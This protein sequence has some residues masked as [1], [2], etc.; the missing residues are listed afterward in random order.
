MTITAD[1]DD[2]RRGPEFETV[3]L[4]DGET[5]LKIPSSCF[6]HTL[7]GREREFRQSSFAELAKRLLPIVSSDRVE[8]EDYAV[9]SEAVVALVRF[10]PQILN[11]TRLEEA[12]WQRA[13]GSD[14]V[15]DYSP[16]NA[17]E[18][19]TKN[20]ILYCLDCLKL[21]ENQ[22]LSTEQIERWREAILVAAGYSLRSLEVSHRVGETK[23]ND[24]LGALR[25]QVVEFL[26]QHP[27]F[28]EAGKEMVARWDELIDLASFYYDGYCPEFVDGFSEASLNSPSEKE[29]LFEN[30]QRIAAY[31]N[32]MAPKGSDD[33]W[34]QALPELKGRLAEREAAV[35][36]S[37]PPYYSDKTTEAMLGLLTGSLEPG[38]GCVLIGTK[39]L[40]PLV[41]SDREKR[42]F[43]HLAREIN[44]FLDC[45]TPTDIR[46]L[47][48]FLAFEASEDSSFF[49]RAIQFFESLQQHA[50]E[51]KVPISLVAYPEDAIA[52]RNAERT[53]FFGDL[54]IYDELQKVNDW[55]PLTIRFTVSSAAELDLTEP[56]ERPHSL[57][58]SAA[59]DV[60]TRHGTDVYGFGFMP[61]S[62]YDNIEAELGPSHPGYGF[63]DELGGWRYDGAIFLHRLEG[64]EQ[65]D[66]IPADVEP[67]K[68]VLV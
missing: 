7:W 13:L 66:E 31:G 15:Q 14:F 19:T 60:A 6:D 18:E 30:L 4:S 67:S 57:Y 17:A 5:E 21:T 63:L 45:D 8:M 54:R 25:D 23:T 20:N 44:E 12:Q 29:T 28:R 33:S 48:R 38:T 37:V 65:G 16:R 52:A 50:H 36:V 27:A 51:Q 68:L 3:R 55:K 61:R 46:S 43:G 11:E 62:L 49:P 35:E 34:Y 9:G 58:Q 64:E 47:A 1:Q 2:R 22:E 42:T 24:P 26:V 53:L 39:W 41:D 59:F 32:A 40:G 56:I 10:T